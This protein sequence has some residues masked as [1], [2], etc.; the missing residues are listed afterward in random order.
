MLY[1]E[2]EKLNLEKGD[3]IKIRWEWDNR[4]IYYYIGEIKEISEKGIILDI[5]KEI[6]YLGNE[7]KDK[8]RWYRNCIKNVIFC[9][10][11]IDEI[12][13]IKRAN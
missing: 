11:E 12:E 4:Y 5:E 1:K 3:K 9:N 2:I 13:I 10:E 6:D 8:N 7:V